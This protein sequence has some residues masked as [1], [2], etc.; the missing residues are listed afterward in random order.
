MTDGKNP[1]FS[2]ARATYGIA[3]QILENQPH[4]QGRRTAAFLLRHSIEL[5]LKGILLEKMVQEDFTTRFLKKHSIV[6]LVTA[7]RAYVE[8]VDEAT[9]EQVQKLENSDPKSIQYRYPVARET[10][11]WILLNPS[12]RELQWLQEL[13]QAFLSQVFTEARTNPVC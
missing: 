4:L 13:N 10:N 8:F 5:C 6:E 7:C 1:W 9:L 3:L 12:D 11:E 2:S